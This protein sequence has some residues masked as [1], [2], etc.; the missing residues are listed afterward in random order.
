MDEDRLS[1]SVNLDA[2]SRLSQVGQ[3]GI[4]M[5]SYKHGW[6][7]GLG[8]VTAL[9]VASCGN[10]SGPD[11]DPAPAPPPATS[12]AEETAAVDPRLPEGTYQTPELTVDQ[13]VA[14]GVSAGFGE[15]AVEEFWTVDNGV[16][17]DGHVVLTLKL[18]S[19][20]WTQFGSHDGG[21]DEIGWSGTY[22]V[23]DDDTV[24]ATDP[25]GAITYTYALRGDELTLDMIEDECEGYGGD[26]PQDELIAQTTIFET[27]PF[28]KVG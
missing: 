9:L 19:G 25:C 26:D 18:E 27:A 8:A 24:V 17:P 3:K 2:G 4:T 13:L 21:P 7:V 22:E 14:A 23:V 5:I 12:A 10:G 11:A 1:V 20:R 6:Q 15:A 16:S 28:T